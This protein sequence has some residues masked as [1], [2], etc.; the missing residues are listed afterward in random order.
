LSAEAFEAKIIVHSIDRSCFIFCG[1]LP[2]KKNESE[3]NPAPNQRSH[4]LFDLIHVFKEN[5]SFSA[6]LVAEGAH[7][8]RRNTMS[9]S[10]DGERLME[11]Y[12]KMVR[13]RSF[14]SQLDRL[15]MAGMVHGSIHTSIGQEAVAVGVCEALQVDDVV[16]GGHRSHGLC[17]LKGMDMKAMF[18][19]LC[20]RKTGTCKGK[21]G[22]MHLMDPSKGMI[23]ANGIVAQQ[24]PIAAGVGLAIQVKKTGQVCACFFGDGASNAGVFHEALNLASIWKLPVVYICEN[25]L[26]ALTVSTSTSTS[27]ED[28]AVRAKSY[29]IP[30]LVVDGMDVVKVYEAAVPA[31]ERARSG[32]GPTLIE[33]KTYRYMGH[34]RGDPSFGPY[35]TKEEWEKWRQRDPIKNLG[36]K[37][38]L[39]QEEI[40]R[41]ENEIDED[42][43]QAITF[44]EKSPYPEQ[45]QSLEDIY[46]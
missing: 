31:I 2:L 41:I 33:C 21:A 13:I 32:D 17:L 15:Y 22:S 27:V 19:E 42:I 14:E 34:S 9:I 7:Y 1:Q 43:Q 25:N 35:R 5:D 44:A 30:G 37:L 4:C 40:K 24:M 39:P 36:E 12:E 11:F 23:G 38:H 16:T 8:K 46:F 6:L 28:I 20:G 3:E 18:A 10:G 26:Y 45:T 29:N